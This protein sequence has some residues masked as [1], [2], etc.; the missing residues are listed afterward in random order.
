MSRSNVVKPLG[1]SLDSLSPGLFTAS[2]PIPLQTSKVFNE[3]GPA[4]FRDRSMR[5]GPKNSVEPVGGF[6]NNSVEPVGFQVSG[7]LIVAPKAVNTSFG[8]HFDRFGAKIGPVLPIFARKPRRFQCKRIALSQSEF[9]KKNSVE[10][11]GGFANNSVEPVGGLRAIP[12]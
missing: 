11:V 1:V 8:A 5:V 3:P 9:T 2:Q 12:I 6:A 7:P 4:L 10:P